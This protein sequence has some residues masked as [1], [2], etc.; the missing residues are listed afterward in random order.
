[1]EEGEIRSYVTEILDECILKRFAL[2]PG[3]TV[4]NY[5]PVRNY[6]AMIDEARRW[7][8]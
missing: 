8:R 7:T 3:N 2:G 1:M 5:V 6:L 4:A